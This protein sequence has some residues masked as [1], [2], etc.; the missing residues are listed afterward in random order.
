MSLYVPGGPTSASVKEGVIQEFTETGELIFQWRAWDHYD[1][2]QSGTDFPHMNALEVDE[3][4][5]L[6]VSS[7]HLN[8]VTKI[9]RDTGEIIWRLSGA[10]SSFTFVND[11]LNG[12]RHQ[13]NISALG[14]GRYM[15]FDNGNGRT[16]Q[17]SR[18]VEYELDLTNLTAT[19]VW[20]FRDTPDK[21]SY[22]FGSSQR[23]PT[24]NTLINFVRAQYPK[25]IEVDADGAKRF[26]LSLVPSADGYRAFRFPWNGMVEVP[27]LILE[28][29]RDNVAL[30]FNKFGDT[31][32]SYYR[33]YGGTS[34]QPTTLL[35]TSTTTLKHLTNLENGRRYYFRISA[36]N[37]EGIESGFSNEESLI[38]NIVKPGGQMVVNGG[39]SLGTSPWAWT[40]TGGAA[41]QWRITNGVSF[42]DITNGGSAAAS[43]QLRQA[44]MPLWQGRK[45]VFEFDAWSQSPRYIE[46]KVAQSTSP[47]LNH[48]GIGVSFVTPTPTHYRYVF[49]MEAAS[50]FNA[51]VM[52]NLGTSPFD[53]FLDNVSLFNV[54]P[55]DFNLDGKVDYQDLAVLAGDWLQKQPDLVT[56]L[57]GNGMVDLKDFAVF[58]E[59]WNGTGP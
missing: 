26:E 44:G 36:V 7:R 32:V 4:G 9:N 52:F 11:P 18:S 24:G 1:V 22:W 14:N 45:Y 10:N 31:D 34:P 3:D 30:I 51:S 33:I 53:V 2:S 17:V 58:G 46:A 37:S 40:V 47:F 13:H 16:P 42:F 59:N 54:P 55:G 43:L 23:L 25:A 50:D 35:A 39:F 20:Q 41:G 49:T 8:E 57:D 15:V 21:Y 56:D 12:I 27:Y 48:S 5:H 28:L 6:L 29:Q 19:L 38:V